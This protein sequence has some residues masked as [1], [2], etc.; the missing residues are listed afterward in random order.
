M[1]SE[2]KLQGMVDR[3]LEVRQRFSEYVSIDTDRAAISDMLIMAECTGSRT[4][5]DMVE[6]LLILSGICDKMLRDRGVDDA[7]ERMKAEYDRAVEKHGT[8]K[9]LTSTTMPDDMKLFALVE[10]IGEVAR[11]LTY[12]KEHAGDLIEE[13]VQVGGLALAWAYALDSE[14]Q[15]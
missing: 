15:S 7:F 14:E 6:D 5:D 12:D 10:E 11:C 8:D 9:V 3:A 2:H 1:S 13:A 4:R